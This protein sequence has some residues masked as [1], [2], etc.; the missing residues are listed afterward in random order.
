MLEDASLLERAGC[1]SLVLEGIPFDLAGQITDNL[2]IPTIGI[3]AGPRCDGQV[4]VFHDLLGI[5]NELRPRF[6]KRYAE[7]NDVMIDAVAAFRSEVRSGVFPD[8]EHSYGADEGR[9]PRADRRE[10]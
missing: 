6:V 1:F 10:D 9:P 3:G 2:A 7:L 8:L 5:E 4:L